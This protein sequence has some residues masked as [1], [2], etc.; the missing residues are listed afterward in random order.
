LTS[1]GAYGPADACAA[2][3]RRRR[4]AS[5]GSSA[6]RGQNRHGHRG[7]EWHE[8]GRSRRLRVVRIG[9]I[10]GQRRRV[11]RPPGRWDGVDLQR[12]AR[13]SPTDAGEMGR[14]QA[15]EALSEAVSVERRTPP[16]ILAPGEHPAFRHACPHLRACGVAVPHREDEGFAATPTGQDLRRMGEAGAVDDGRDG[17]PPSHAS[18]H[19][20]MG[21]GRKPLHSQRPDAPPG[22][23][24]WPQKASYWRSASEGSRTP[25]PIKHPALRPNPLNMARTPQLARRSQPSAS[26]SSPTWCCAMSPPVMKWWGSQC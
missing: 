11:L 25:L 17:E 22:Q 2:T 15:I 9:T 12:V 1:P 8:P 10:E 19:G 23:S 3:L 26:R 4:H 6:L 5:G 18:H 21:H 7:W 13:D 20:Y 24:A 16:A 14:K